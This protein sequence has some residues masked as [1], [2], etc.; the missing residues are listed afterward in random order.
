MLWIVDRWS[1]CRI[2]VRRVI[3]WF[4]VVVIIYFG[5]FLWL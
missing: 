4:F 1:K 3:Y 5:F 2:L